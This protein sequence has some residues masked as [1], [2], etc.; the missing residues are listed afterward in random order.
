MKKKQIFI[1]DTGMFRNEFI[2]AC[3]YTK[4]DIVA[5]CKKQ[6]VKKEYVEFIRDDV[7]IEKLHSG[8]QT[9]Q[10]WHHEVQKI[11]LLIT[12]EVKDEWEFWETILHEVVHAVQHMTRWKNLENEDE[13]QA[14]LVEYLFRNIRRKLQGVEKY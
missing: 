13:C 8:A 1:Q 9:G 5:W 12:S 11:M 10:L 4:D 7:N 6:K 3:G 2:V 14:Y